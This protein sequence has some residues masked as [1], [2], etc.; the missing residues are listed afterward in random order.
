MEKYNFL[1]KCSYAECEKY[2]ICARAKSQSSAE[3][4]YKIWCL[5]LSTKR[6]DWFIPIEGDGENGFDE[7]ISGPATASC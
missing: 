3:A 5:P 2:K 1:V 6:Y 7:N 4:N